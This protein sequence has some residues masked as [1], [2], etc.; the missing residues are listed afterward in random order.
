MKL[1]TRLLLPLLT[2]V[3]AVM[4]AFGGWAIIQRE[5]TL[6]AE[7]ERETLAYARALG[8]ALERTSRAPELGGMEELIDRVDREPS[9]YGVRVYET[10]GAVRYESE[11][12]RGG[13][14]AP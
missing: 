11:P 14:R 12:L 1:S 7:A 10:S 13:R 2:T 9:I 8:L 6:L 5:D 3:G 4:L